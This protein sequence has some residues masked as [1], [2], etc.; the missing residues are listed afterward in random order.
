MVPSDEREAQVPGHRR[1]IAIGREQGVTA[2]DAEGADDQ[3]DGLAH[4]NTLKT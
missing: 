1:E 2:G 3:V 4:S